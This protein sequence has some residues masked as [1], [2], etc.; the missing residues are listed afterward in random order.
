MEE[1]EFLLEDSQLMSILI[2]L[3]L[4]GGIIG[5]IQSSLEHVDQFVVVVFEGHI[6]VITYFNPGTF[7]V[8]F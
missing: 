6:V 4:V 7:V 3:I 5:V 8:I 1:I 2:A